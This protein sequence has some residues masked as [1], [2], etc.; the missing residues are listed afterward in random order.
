MQIKK[1]LLMG[2]L[3]ACI[4]C[5]QGQKLNKSSIKGQVS[6]DQKKA[7]PYATV[8]LVA[9]DK[10]VATEQHGNYQFIGLA[11]GSYIVKLTGGQA[12]ATKIFI[13]Q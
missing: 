11:A 8:K 12:N 6:D 10:T 4:F 5:A 3:C 2:I 1:I 13:K 9:G 7:I